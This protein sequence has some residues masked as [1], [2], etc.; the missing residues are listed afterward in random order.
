MKLSAFA[1]AAA[2]AL[3]L[4]APARAQDDYVRTELE[5]ASSLLTTSG[6]AAAA[7]AVIGSL[8]AGA[9]QQFDLDLRRGVQ[10]VVIGVC[11]RGCSDLDLVIT[12]AAGAEVDADRELD[13]VPVLA[14]SP[15]QNGTFRIKVEMATCSTA[16]CTFGVRV[17]QAQS[18]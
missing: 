4:A 18:Q 11:D 15:E 2:A 3:L 16:E 9:D 8:A 7:D 1:L 14:V 12:N 17:F 13:D 6:Y 10:Y 5:S